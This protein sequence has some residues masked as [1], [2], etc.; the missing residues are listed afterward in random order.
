VSAGNGGVVIHCHAGCP[1]EAVLDALSRRG[2]WGSPLA[3]AA[4]GVV[5][6][7]HAAANGAVAKVTRY[8]V[9]NLEGEILAYHV[10]RDFPD[11]RKS[12]AWELPGGRPGLGGLR[13]DELPLYIPPDAMGID[14]A[15]ALVVTEGEKAAEALAPFA[16]ELGVA[17][18]GTVTGAR[19]APSPE[20]LRPYA[21]KVRVIFLWPDRDEAGQHHMTK[22]AAN[23]RA[24]G[25]ADIR[26]ITWPDAPE[27]G[28]AAD[29]TATGATVDDLRALLRQ[30]STAPEEEPREEAEAETEPLVTT[31]Q[32]WPAPIAGEAFHGLAGEVV[33]A[34]EPHSESDPVAILVQML[35]AFGSAA[36]RRAYFPVEADRHYSNLFAVLVGETAKGRKGTS[37]GHVLRLFDYADPQWRRERVV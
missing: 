4:G 15:R 23:F 18:A 37:L 11:G 17:V 14:E 33:R 12:I 27:K 6:V 8:A 28:D 25:A 26:L 3:A 1:Q 5:L 24:A 20:A 36:G 19:A 30:A 7:R 13:V 29:F 34:I 35:V 9:T 22:V 32:P 2:L 21:Q 16:A 10:R 31:G